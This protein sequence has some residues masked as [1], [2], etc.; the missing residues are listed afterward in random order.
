MNSDHDQTSSLAQEVAHMTFKL[1]CVDGSHYVMGS[2]GPNR[3]IWAALFPPR[4]VRIIHVPELNYYAFDVSSDGCRAANGC[5]HKRALDVWDLKTGEHVLRIP[6]NNISELMLDSTGRF[7]LH[8][9]N[10]RVAV[11]SLDDPENR[12]WIRRCSYLY[13]AS[14]RTHHHAVL[15]PGDKPGALIQYCFSSKTQKTLN[16]NHHAIID[17]IVSAP[18]ESQLLL[19]DAMGQASMFAAPDEPPIWTVTTPPIRTSSIASFSGDGTLVM[20]RDGSASDTYVFDAR[21]GKLLARLDVRVGRSRPLFGTKVMD[22]YGKI[23]DLATGEVETGVSNW[24]WWR[25]IGA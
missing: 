25:A 13:G 5:Y 19:V 16:T 7:V 8:R 21:S 1:Y 14:L 18:S 12:T 3:L 22:S 4:L 9:N 15:I 23:F 20:I 24:R 10:S 6:I 11:R 2:I 17:T